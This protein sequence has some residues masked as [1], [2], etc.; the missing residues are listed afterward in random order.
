MLLAVFGIAVLFDAA[1]TPEIILA[2]ILIVMGI[3]AALRRRLRFLVLGVAIVA[4]LIVVV[5]F[6]VTHWRFGLGVAAL[7]ASIALA[8]ANLRALIARR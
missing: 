6:L 8:T 4:A 2:T 1:R 5:V 7:T 3:E